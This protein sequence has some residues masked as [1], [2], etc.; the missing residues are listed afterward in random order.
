M[1]KPA[2]RGTKKTRAYAEAGA[3][4]REDKTLP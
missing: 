4:I 3:I 2:G 1:K